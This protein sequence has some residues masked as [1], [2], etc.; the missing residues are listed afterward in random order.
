MPVTRTQDACA[1]LIRRERHLRDSSSCSPAISSCRASSSTCC[2][3]ESGKCDRDGK[4]IACGRAT[5]RRALLRVS[6]KAIRA[7]H[8]QIPPSS[9]FD[10]G[11]QD[12]RAKQPRPKSATGRFG[13]ASEIRFLS[14]SVFSNRRA[15]GICRIRT[16]RKRQSDIGPKRR[17]GACETSGA[18]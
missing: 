15:C 4:R 14:D 2:V 8:G 16:Q 9:R 10:T 7:S 13:R 6:G 18:R 5:D 12:C 1:P 11:S 3:C 17:A